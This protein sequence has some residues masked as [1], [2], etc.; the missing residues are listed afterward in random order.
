MRCRRTVKSQLCTAPRLNSCFRICV[1][2]N[3]KNPEPMVRH[4]RYYIAIIYTF[5][6]IHERPTGTSI[7]RIKSG[8]GRLV[9]PGLE[10]SPI[11]CSRDAFVFARGMQMNLGVNYLSIV[12]T[13][14][15]THEQCNHRKLENHVKVEVPGISCA[16]PSRAVIRGPTWDSLCCRA[17]KLEYDKIHLKLVFIILHFNAESSSHVKNCSNCMRPTCTGSTSTDGTW[18]GSTTSVN[19]HCLFRIF[20][21]LL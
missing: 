2:F 20:A 16:A 9:L 12:R 3:S 5:W 4:C 8:K 7:L 13:P 11:F 15:R 17:V 18:P 19:I 1:T 6:I 10:P 21:Y 14:V